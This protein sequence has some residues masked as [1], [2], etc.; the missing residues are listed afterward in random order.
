MLDLIPFRR[1]HG[2]P[3]V[4]EE[5]EDVFKKMWQG[6]FLHDLTPDFESDWSP[7]LDVTETDAAIEVIADLPGLDKS[8]I[9]I[10]LD[11]DI[12]VIKGEKKEEHK[13]TDKHVHRVERRS[14]S[15]YRALRLPVEVKSEEIDASFKKGVLKITLPKSE[16]DI[17]KVAHI[18]VH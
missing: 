15:F 18:E 8:D 2:V 17:K 3:D 6:S 14:G 1:R 12:L 10:S 5:M 9:D 13:Q 4:F 16:E 11:R 7:R